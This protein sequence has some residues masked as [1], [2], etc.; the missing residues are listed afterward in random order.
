MKTRF[1]AVQ[2]V[3]IVV[4]TTIGIGRVTA[5]AQSR[6]RPTFPRARKALEAGRAR[7][8]TLR[9]LV[10]TIDRSN[11]IVHIVDGS[12][13]GPRTRACT[14]FVAQSGGSRYL[15]ITIAEFLPPEA[16][17][18]VLAHELQHIAEIAEAPE[19]NSGGKLATLFAH[20]GW[21]AGHGSFESRRAI[22][23]STRVAGELA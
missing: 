19:V 22:D 9:S 7:S 23:L 12:C 21:S 5:A 3:A 15:R 1:S 14:T 4:L 20:A 6:V 8:P 16:I 18:V 17:I 13:P 10:D 11:V 2:V